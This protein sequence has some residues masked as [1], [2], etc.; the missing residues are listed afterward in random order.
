MSETKFTPGPWAVQPMH[1]IL[2]IGT[3]KDGGQLDE[4]ILHINQDKGYK[5]EKKERNLANAKLIAAAPDLYEALS[6][7]ATELE[8]FLDVPKNLS[9]TNPGEDNPK[10]VA[11]RKAMNALKKATE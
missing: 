2:W 1:Q 8:I 7:C 9:D 10:L 4:L 11:Y 3:P 5:E 6:E